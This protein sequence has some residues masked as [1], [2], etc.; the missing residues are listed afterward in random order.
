MSFPFYRQLDNTDCGPTC[1]R[2]IA[3]YYGKIFSREYL[4][5]KSFITREGVS[6][7]GISEAA[8]SIGMRSLAVKVSFESLRH[9]VPLP[10]IA[11]WR[12]RH[13]VVVHKVT[14]KHVFV[15]DPGFGLIKYSLDKF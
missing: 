12:Q 7:A 5:D 10:C 14:K 15:A 13:F 4:R 2:M 9:E 8:E 1:L 6:V 3:K 11:H